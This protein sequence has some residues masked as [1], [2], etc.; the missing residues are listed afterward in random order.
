MKTNRKLLL[1]VSTMVASAGLTAG[2]GSDAGVNPGH[3]SANA[4][5]LPGSPQDRIKAIQADRSMSE[6]EKKRRITAIKQRNHLQ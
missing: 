6:V 5:I 1:L 3:V 2:C 4:Y